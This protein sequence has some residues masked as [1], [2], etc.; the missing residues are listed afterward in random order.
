VAKHYR[1][2]GLDRTARRMVGFLER[3]GLDGASVLEIG[4]GLGE[5]QLELLKRGAADATNLEL[6]DAY[7]EEA[8][9]L[10]QEAGLEDRVRRRRHDIA[11]APD[12]VEPADI[13]VLHR[14]VC[15]YP[16]YERLLSAAAEHARRL[17]VFSH[18][19]HHLPARTL[20]AGINLAMRV[21]GMEYRTFN[22]PPAAMVCV[23]ER[24]GLQPV[25]THRGPV[26]HVVAAGR[27]GH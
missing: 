21:R 8:H 2:H 22:H 24:H 19:P 18:P 12:E 23:L 17:V 25:Y 5:V 7:D 4:G 20:M 11:V 27:T 1:R 26:W 9:R 14:V 16:D 6:S 3:C 10:L 13:V 15:C